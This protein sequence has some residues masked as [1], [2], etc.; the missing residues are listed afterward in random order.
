MDDDQN[1]YGILKSDFTN[2][3]FNDLR[4]IFISA[5]ILIKII[6]NSEKSAIIV[7]LSLHDLFPDIIKNKL[8]D[9]LYNK[10]IETT[11][12]ITKEVTDYLN[13]NF[14]SDFQPKTRKES[15]YKY[16]NDYFKNYLNILK[17]GDGICIE[18][19]TI[20]DFEI[21]ESKKLNLFKISLIPNEFKIKY[22]KNIIKYLEISEE[23]YH[24]TK[25]VAVSLETN[26]SYRKQLEFL[27]EYLENRQK[28]TG[29]IYFDFKLSDFNFRHSILSFE[30]ANGIFTMPSPLA[31]GKSEK[32]LLPLFL[33]TQ[34]IIDINGIKLN[35]S[36][37][38]NVNDIDIVY[39]VTKPAKINQFLAIS[40]GLNPEVRK[41]MSETQITIYER[42]YTQNKSN[43]LFGSRFK[44]EKCFAELCSWLLK[45][46]SYCLE[47]PSFLKDKSE[48]WLSDHVS[49]TYKQ[50]EDNFFLPFLFEKLKYDFGDLVIKKPEAF[51]GEI[52]ILFG[53]IPIELKVRRKESEPLID[54]IVDDKFNP[55]SQAAAYASTV[56]VGFVVL[57]DLPESNKQITNL[58]NCVRIIEKEFDNDSLY[59]TVINLFVFYCNQP[60]PSSAS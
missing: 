5:I 36:N 55:A 58:D 38:L 56:R 21:V 22:S 32:V 40:F 44:I 19:L 57:L 33:E 24:K 52:D 54:N 8:E 34:A 23:I 60:V 41:S 27:N 29:E 25:N 10:E 47:D 15:A 28:N 17:K 26:I 6:N 46:T 31:M 1:I 3:H 45:K 7:E 50:M 16:Y 13:F 43:Y 2:L 49:D 51:G 37:P 9:I 35:S 4:E 59:K 14:G 48:K 11:N 42:I 12:R 53:D 39:S 30:D 20:L 18:P